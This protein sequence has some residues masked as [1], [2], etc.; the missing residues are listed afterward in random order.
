[1]PLLRA[2]RPRIKLMMVGADPSRAVTKLGELPGVTVTGSVADVRPYLWASAATIALL[3]IARRTQNKVLEAMAAGVPTVVSLA[4]IG[5]IDAEP[6]RRLL[7]ATTPG[8]TP[9]RLSRSST[10]AASAGASR[11]RDGPGSSL[12]TAGSER[13]G[14]WVDF[15]PEVRPGCRGASTPGHGFQDRGRTP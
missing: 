4:A 14:C 15:S 1:M 5:G 9:K 10:T 6:G 11:R 13:W 8:S 2:R 3:R 12:M 7:T